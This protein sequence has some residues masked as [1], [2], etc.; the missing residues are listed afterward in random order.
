MNDVIQFVDFCSS[1]LVC[2]NLVMHMCLHYYLCLCTDY[3]SFE[4]GE[5]LS[6]HYT[7][8]VDTMLQVITDLTK[9]GEKSS[10]AAINIITEVWL[11]ALARKAIGEKELKKYSSPSSNGKCDVLKVIP[12]MIPQ[13]GYSQMLRR[14]RNVRFL[15]ASGYLY[16]YIYTYTS[17]NQY[18]S[19]LYS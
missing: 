12:E 4:E 17:V 19:C 18:T 3:C 11:K 13:E 9:K 10:L 14:E 1:M 16:I 7:V 5:R 6:N 2:P 15:S 8:E